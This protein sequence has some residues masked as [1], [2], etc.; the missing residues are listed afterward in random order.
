MRNLQNDGLKLNY[1]NL[2]M[3]N[4]NS[5]PDVIEEGTSAVMGLEISNNNLE[6]SKPGEKIIL[7]Q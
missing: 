3:L 6:D 1:S 7:Y 5:Q 4:K 2:F